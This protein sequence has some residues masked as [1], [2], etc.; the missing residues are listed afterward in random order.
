MNRV[1]GERVPGG[2]KS[3]RLTGSDAG[4]PGVKGQRKAGGGWWPGSPRLAREILQAHG[5]GRGWAHHGR[6][7]LV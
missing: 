6:S 2:G 4:T 7:D 5:S 3:G 1:H